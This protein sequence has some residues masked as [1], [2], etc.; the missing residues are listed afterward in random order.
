MA[1][2]I[3]ESPGQRFRRRLSQPLVYGVALLIAGVSIGPVVYAFLGGFRSN[4]QLIVDPIGL[5]NPWNIDN[6][7][8]ILG[9]SRFW[10]PL[11][12][13]TLVAVLT[14][15]GVVILG[16]M[17]AYPLARYEFKGREAVYTFFVLGL[18]FPATVAILPLFILIRDI[19]LYD[20]HFGLILPQVAFGL[21]LTVVILRPFLRAIPAELQDAAE[22]DGCSRVGFFWRILL[23]L[24]G[25]GLVT[26]GVLAFVGSWNAYLLPLLLLRSSSLHTLPLG[27]A[28]FQSQFSADTAMIL[29]FTSLS[30]IPA[31]VF[32]L[33][34][35][36]RIVAGLQGAVKG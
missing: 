16:V 22:I 34:A 25:P 28:A 21:P 31:L 29:A 27:V 17:A 19:G 24:A 32:F 13:S 23:P 36:R 9:S 11:F 18:L 15:A 5:P 1:T 33:M 26:V 20:N 12:N 7:L 6:Y 14:T 8:E 35:E 4:Q 2:S 10:I 30:M 3:V